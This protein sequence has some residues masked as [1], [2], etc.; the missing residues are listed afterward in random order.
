MF[1]FRNFEL[2]LNKELRCSLQ[3]I[4]GIGIRKSNLILSKF[5]FAYPFFIGNL[6][7]YKFLLINFLLKYLVLSEVRVKRVLN[8]RIRELV[9]IQSYR[10]LRHRDFLP[11][12]GQRTRTNA[13][14]RKQ[15]R[16]RK[17]S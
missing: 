13:S 17:V 7:L 10:G 5:G 4:R 14:T 9:S 1:S 16:F 6:N 2:P 11:V 15:D 3:S 8:L 12:R